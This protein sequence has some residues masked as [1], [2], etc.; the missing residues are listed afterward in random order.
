MMNYTTYVQSIANLTVVPVSDTNFQTM[1]PNM[2]DDAEQRLY[3]ELDLLN[4]VV[5]DS[6]S[7]FTISTRTFNLPST[8]GTFVTVDHIY[9]IT[10]VGTAPDSGTRN[11]LLPAS[12]AYLTMLYPSSNGSSVPSYF[13]PVTQTSFIVG[14]W[15]D[16]AYR[17][18]VVGTIRPPAIST[19]NAT[20]LL[21]VYFPDLF[22]AASMVFAAGYLQNYG[23]TVDNPQQ[24]VTWEAHY[25]AL[26]S[27]A[28]VEEAR[29]KFTS[30]GWS[31]KQPAPLAT[32]PRN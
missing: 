1:I 16:Q 2:I 20:T 21:S 28:Q 12:E 10:P 25:K 6:T 23:S 31:S 5:R 11:A 29:K 32:P 27:S 18:E 4:T 26:L 17:V 9:A 14:P 8:N 22:V 30:E 19:T 3:R 15:P 13:A 24:G 7:T